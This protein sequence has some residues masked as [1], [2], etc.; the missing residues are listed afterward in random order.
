MWNTTGEFRIVQGGNETDFET[1]K[2]QKIALV[3][4]ITK[5]S[6]EDQDKTRLNTR[7]WKRLSTQKNAILLSP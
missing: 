4:N 2:A 1:Q 3:K 6:L 5:R 7:T